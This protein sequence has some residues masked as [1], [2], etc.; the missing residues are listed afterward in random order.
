L[1]NFEHLTPEARTTLAKNIIG[2]GLFVLIGFPDAG[3]PVCIDNGIAPAHKMKALE[4]LGKRWSLPIEQWTTLWRALNSQEN[5]NGSFR[6]S[7]L[8]QIDP[9]ESLLKRG[10]RWATGAPQG[11]QVSESEESEEPVLTP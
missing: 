6:E 5:D 11:G 7:E 1:N 8:R 4:E 2:K 3:K 9:P 10:Y